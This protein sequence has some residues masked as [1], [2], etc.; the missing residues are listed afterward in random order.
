MFGPM[1]K[2]NCMSNSSERGFFF[3]LLMRGA[4]FKLE[5]P[6]VG[7]LKGQKVNHICNL[8]WKSNT[9]IEWTTMKEGMS[10]HLQVWGSEHTVYFLLTMLILQ[11]NICWEV[12]HHGW[13]PRG[14]LEWSILYPQ[15]V[16][17]RWIPLGIQFRTERWH[18][19]SGLLSVSV[20]FHMQTKCEG[21]GLQLQELSS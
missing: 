4:I 5:V 16:S 12:Q 18:Q 17:K 1:D 3:F 11:P 15:Y 14:E 20:L 8:V 21:G 9:H 6:L 7:L 2:K 19:M 10:V 13:Y